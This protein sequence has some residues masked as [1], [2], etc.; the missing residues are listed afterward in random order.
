MR[1]FNKLVIIINTLVFIVVGIFGIAV[2]VN[3]K[4][5]KWALDIL[6]SL[7]GYLN[8]SAAASVVV[9]I[10]SFFLITIAILTIVGNIENR[11]VERTVILESPLGDIMV[12]LSAIEDFSRVVKNQVSGVKDIKGKVLSKR[13]GIDVTAKVA[14]YSDRSVAEV[15]QEVQEAIIKY[16]QYTL[17]IS[18]AIKPTVIVNKIVYKTEEKKPKEKK[19]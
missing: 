15:T 18:T 12:S 14:L 10:F 1:I 11:R 17:S 7:T 3:Q 2:S 5:S 4:A 6:E 8:I 13:K 9:F 16:I 19:Q